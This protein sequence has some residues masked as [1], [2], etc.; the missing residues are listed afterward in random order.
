MPSTKKSKQREKREEIRK[1]PLFI[2]GVRGLFALPLKAFILG[3]KNALED[4][5]P[6]QEKRARQNAFAKYVQRIR[7]GYVVPRLERMG[8]SFT[9]L[10]EKRTSIFVNKLSK[11]LAT[12]AAK[13]RVVTPTLLDELLPKQRAFVKF[14]NYLR[15]LKGRKTV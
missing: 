1:S 2:R 6:I 10:S 11:E 12:A 4:I 8:A 9:S 5:K 7:T 13:K 14:Q 15:R 3:P